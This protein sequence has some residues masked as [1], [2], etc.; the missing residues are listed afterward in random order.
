[1][2][3]A[4]GAFNPETDLPLMNTVLADEVAQVNALKGEGRLGY[5]GAGCGRRKRKTEASA[6]HVRDGYSVSFGSPFVIADASTLPTS[7]ASP[8]IAESKPIV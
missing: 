1:M 4:G 5:M 3:L 6:S 2:P 8:G 7:A